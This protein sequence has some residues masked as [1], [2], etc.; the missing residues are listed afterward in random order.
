MI[1]SFIFLV[2]L[3]SLSLSEGSVFDNFKPFDKKKSSDS[4][5]DIVRANNSLALTIKKMDIQLEMM[6]IQLQR[7]QIK[8]NSL[9]NQ[10]QIASK[11]MN[12]YYKTVAYQKQFKAFEDSVRQEHYDVCVNNMLIWENRKLWADTYEDMCA[13][14]STYKK[15][16][17]PSMILGKL[18]SDDADLKEGADVG[19]AV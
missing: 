16:N 12:N 8:N 9:I 14:Y 4:G 6:R 17:Y 7:E 18:P 1:K 13:S 2:L 3:S 19:A 11:R 15:I 5:I 10:V